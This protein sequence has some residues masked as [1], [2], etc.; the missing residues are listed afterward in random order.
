M[1][2]L[3]AF[4]GK[5]AGVAVWRQRALSLAWVGV[6]AFLA[7]CAG[8]GTISASDPA[9]KKEAEVRRLAKARWDALIARRMDVAYEYLSPATRKVTT[10]EQY[11]AR[12]NPGM[13]RS[14][15]IDQVKCEAEICRVTLFLTYDHKLMKGIQT[16]LEESWVLDQGRFWFVY[17]S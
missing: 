13:Y 6:A 8:F 2:F 17:R 15:R 9:E 3:G 4:R 5:A 14:V 1:S 16:P 11:R 7:G 10:L 12:V